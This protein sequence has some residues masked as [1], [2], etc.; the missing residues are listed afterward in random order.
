MTLIDDAGETGKRAGSTRRNRKRGRRNNGGRKR[1]DR[2]AGSATR[3]TG[4][5]DSVVGND[6]VIEDVV[7]GTATSENAPTD[8]T[9]AS[10]NTAAEDTATDG[11]A[12]DETATSENTATEDTATEDAATDGTATTDEDD[13]AE[14]TATDEA[15]SSDDDAATEDADDERTASDDED[16]KT[17]DAATE[18]AATEDADDEARTEPDAAPDD[19]PAPETEPTPAP[20]A[21]PTAEA[22]GPGADDRARDRAETA[23]GVKAGPGHEV[24]TGRQVRA[25]ARQALAV[26]VLLGLVGYGLGAARGGGTVAR[27]EFV[28]TLDESVPDSFLREDRRLLTQ[29][30]TFRSDA[31]LTPVAADFD[32]TVDELRSRIDVATLDLS[33]VLRLDVADPDPDRA[34]ALNRAVLDRYLQVIAEAEPAGDRS[35]LAVTRQAIADQ[36]A[37]ADAALVALAQAR[38]EQVALGLEQAAVQR[39][40]DLRNDRIAALQQTIDANPLREDELTPGLNNAVAEQGQLE[41]RLVELATEQARLATVTVEEPALGREIERLEARLATVDAELADRELGPLVA[42]PIRELGAPVTIERSFHVAG[43]QGMAAGLLL[44]VPIAAV[45]AYRAR[46]RQLWF[47]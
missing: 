40:V 26:L 43:L 17:E 28:Y 3:R 2:N 23:A 37:E 44:G 27:A 5:D 30:V 39:Q 25:V 4:G 16:G 14:D 41:A 19:G 31:V 45:F 34:L 21:A 15:A 33:E 38:E 47:D 9:A 6:T 13:A 42:S 29:V 36:L 32:L 18:D 10:E 22:T 24:W 12:A 8:D 46:L 35:E 7:D 1:Q 11:T 20:A